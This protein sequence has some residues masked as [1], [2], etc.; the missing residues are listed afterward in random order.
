[1]KI[2]G[3]IVEYNPLHNGHIYAINQIKKESNADLLI[4]VMS[5]NITMRGDLSLFDKFTKT[6]QALLAGIDIII[7]LPICYTIHN[8]DI[9]AYNSIHFLN[10]AKVDE[11]WIGSESNNPEIFKEAY[12]EFNKTS[13][14]NKIK[15]LMKQGL[16][17]KMATNQIYEL[18]SNDLLGYSYY[19]AIMQINPNIPLKTIKRVGAGYYDN[20]PKEFASA[21][22]IRNNN[23]LVKDFCPNYI[24]IED[25]LEQEQLFPYLKYQILTKTKEEL[26]EIFLVDEG[27]ISY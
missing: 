21:Y 16:S 8:S 20:T 26:K 11:I 14:Q 17:Y 5:T 1:M 24:N 9:F 19:K 2:V 22:S 10:L 13:N 3:T 18:P 12:N 7:E 23:E 27:I 6:K 4:A 25:K 15:E